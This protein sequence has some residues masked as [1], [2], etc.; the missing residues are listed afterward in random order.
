MCVFG[1]RDICLGYPRNE[2]HQHQHQQRHPFHLQ[3]CVPSKA[4]SLGALCC[5]LLSLYLSSLLSLISQHDYRGVMCRKK[6]KKN[7]AVNCCPSVGEWLTF[8]KAGAT[9]PKT[10]KKAAVDNSCCCW[11]KFVAYDCWSKGRFLWRGWTAPLITGVG[12]CNVCAVFALAGLVLCRRKS[13]RLMQMPLP[14]CLTAEK[15]SA[16]TA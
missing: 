9:P 15:L 11:Y 12:N 4:C 2:Q 13:R 1:S 16:P 3:S 14:L 6:E 10:H 5:G 7:T 8:R